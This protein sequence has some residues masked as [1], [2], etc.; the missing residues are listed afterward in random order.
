MQ[1]DSREGRD[2]TMSALHAGKQT[3]TSGYVQ[4]HSFQAGQ[5]SEPC[6]FGNEAGVITHINALSAVAAWN[7]KKCRKNSKRIFFVS[8][9]DCFFIKTF[10]ST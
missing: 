10:L 5:K 1:H 8:F 9:F 6:E 4:G 7:L 2:R 3:I